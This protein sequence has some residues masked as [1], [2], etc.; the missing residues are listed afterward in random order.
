MKKTSGRKMGKSKSKSNRKF[1]SIYI[2]GRR[3]DG[4][5]YPAIA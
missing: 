2:K 5:F 1:F 3:M 4:N